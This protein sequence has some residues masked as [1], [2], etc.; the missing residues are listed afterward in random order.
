[1]P[2]PTGG[3]QH[4][5][6]EMCSMLLSDESTNSKNTVNMTASGKDKKL[7]QLWD[8]DDSPQCHSYGLGKTEHILGRTCPVKDMWC[9]D[10]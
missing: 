4:K 5:A 6:G 10:T 3:Q 8:R 7:I 1:M 2:A 9:I